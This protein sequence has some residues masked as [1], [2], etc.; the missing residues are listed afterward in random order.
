MA[1]VQKLKIIE[2]KFNLTIC[3][4]ICLLVLF[5]IVSC[6]GTD[7]KPIVCFWEFSPLCL[8]VRC[9]LRHSNILKVNIE[10]HNVYKHEFSI[11]SL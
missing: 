6:R 3:A 11:K 10:N 7:E 9:Q 1:S 2:Q 5:P 8:Y 4:V